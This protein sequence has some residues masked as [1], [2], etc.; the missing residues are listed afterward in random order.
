MEVME[1]ET[2]T[3]Q[4]R[5]VNAKLFLFVHARNMNSAHA[6]ERLVLRNQNFSHGGRTSDE[7]SSTRHC[8]L[9]AR[10]EKERRGG[11]RRVR[12]ERW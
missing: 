8:C 6:K 11:V 9:G 1:T 3:E 4:P 12:H 10:E 7:E 5:E 2:G